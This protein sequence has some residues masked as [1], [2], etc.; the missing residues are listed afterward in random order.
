MDKI[1][2]LFGKFE[3]KFDHLNKRIT[4]LQD[5]I[6][7][8]K[9]EFDLIN[10]TKIDNQC[11]SELTDTTEINLDNFLSK[12]PLECKLLDECTT[13]IEK[14]S[15]KIL[16][17]YMKNGIK[18]ALKVLNSYIRFGENYVKEGRCSDKGCMDNAMSVFRS[19]Q[20]ILKSNQR[21]TDDMTN[22]FFNKKDLYTIIDGSESEDSK[23]LTPLSNELRI[24]ILK[25]LSRGGTYYSQLEREV[26]LKG[27]HFHFH[28]DKLIECGYITQES[29]KGPYI[30]TINGL[31]ALKFLFELKQQVLINQ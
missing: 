27:G 7:N 15:I 29:E 10:R 3:E 2:E 12:R 31:K 26:G 9:N 23:L 25:V 30:T 20:N 28:L 19:L 16:K 18:T 22:E 21:I 5:L 13:F 4:F 24:K 6:L 11:M 1:E 17:I 14:K 8:M